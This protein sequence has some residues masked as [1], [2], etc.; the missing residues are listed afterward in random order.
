[1]NMKRIAA[2]ILFFLIILAAVAGVSQ[3]QEEPDPSKPFTSANNRFALD[4]Y[5]KLA[6]GDKNVF[7]SPYGIS[8]SMAGIFGGAKGRTESEIAGVFH[9]TRNKEKLF[10]SFYGSKQPLS[11][12]SDPEVVQ[13]SI[14]NRLWRQKGIDLLPSY[15]KLVKE[16]FEEEPGEL[17]FKEDAE[18]SR[19]AINKWVEEKTGSKI[20]ELFPEGEITK[21]TRLVLTNAVYFKGKWTLPFK[22]KNTKN[23]PFYLAKGKSRQV[24]MMKQTSFFGYTK[25]AECQ[26]VEMPYGYREFSMIILLPKK[27]D[28]LGNLEKTLTEERLRKM[29]SDLGSREVNLSV[30]K[31]KINSDFNLE[32]ILEKMGLKTVFNLSADFSGL[33]GGKDVFVS[34]IIHKTYISIDEYGTEAAAATGVSMAAA[35]GQVPVDFVVDHPFMF[36]ICCRT[37]GEILFIGRVASF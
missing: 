27:L 1:M 29:I 15:L 21:L 4:I 28:G 7:L 24:Q 35:D 20:T 3:A 13:I 8:M 2:N 10:A 11:D 33:T 36:I 5:R 19:V 30:P 23:A 12:F 26:V 9:F 34:S 32:K 16:Y 6:V 18:N 17:N 25:D 31:F 14:A 37:T 22:P